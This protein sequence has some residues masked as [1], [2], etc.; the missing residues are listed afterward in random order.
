MLFIKIIVCSFL[1]D[2]LALL[3]K[4]TNDYFEKL[5]VTFW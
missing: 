4:V 1:I 3:S 5:F 2:D